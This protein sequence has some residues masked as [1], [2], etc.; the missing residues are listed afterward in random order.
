M[1]LE[2]VSLSILGVIL[3]T[4][5]H[6][7]VGALW[8]S[9]LLFVDRWMA[10][11]GTSMD[12]MSGNPMVAVA[13]SVVGAFVTTVILAVIYHW[14]GG[15]GPVDGLVVGLLIG[16]GVV[17]VEGL[18]RPLFESSSW[19]LFWINTGAAVVGFGLAGLVYGMIA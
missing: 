4:V 19:S 5:A 11:L 3:G 6:S 16:A 12:E 9:K 18:N 13:G 2:S 1:H 10:A 8:Y 15:D 7:A 17:C 14:G